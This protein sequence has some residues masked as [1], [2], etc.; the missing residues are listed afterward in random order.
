MLFDLADF[1]SYF[2]PLR[3]FRYL[4]F[5][6]ALAMVLSF[7]IGMA[8]APKIIDTLR[9]I[10]FGQSFR[11]KD[12]V[13]RLAE[14]HSGKKGT[15]A[16]GGIII[17]LAVMASS[18][19]LARMNA[20]VFCALFVYT[21]FTALGFAD[22]YLKIV[23]KNSK[24][25]N[26]KIKLAV[27]IA[28]SLTALA[29][30]LFSREYCGIARE[31]WAPFLKYPIISSMPI[32]F[33]GIFIFLVVGGSSNAI[34]LTDGIDGLAIGCTV[35]VALAY[36]V[37]TY[38]AGNAIASEY[39]FIR[40]IP[41]C[42]ELTVICCA[43]VGAS[44]AFLWY[45]AHPAEVFMGDTGSLAIGGLIGIVAFMCQQPL[46]LV[47]V[48]GVFVMEAVSVMLQVASYKSTKKRIFLMSP[49]HHHFELKGW[50]ETK[51]VIRFWIISLI[52]ALAGLATLKIR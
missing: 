8:C 21:A 50:A 29:I 23:K 45:N 13:G 44:M 2:G 15:P 48:G 1:E 32:C 42:G 37:F 6:C 7:V 18:L 43:L 34:N 16:M 38:V 24:G 49:I 25:V 19:L 20:L 12:E 52:F 47:I 35:S 9:A 17:F 22:D 10:K 31:L 46:T 3:L 40:A 11:T 30:L 27:Q 39:L 36:A 26:G 5:R 51:V 33:A 4:T 28:V 14:L 41:N